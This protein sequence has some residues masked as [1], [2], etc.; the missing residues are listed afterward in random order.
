MKRVLAP[1][2][3]S[4]TPCFSWVIRQDRLPQPFQRLVKLGKPLKRLG[5]FCISATPSSSR[6]L[7]KSWLGGHAFSGRIRAGNRELL[8]LLP[9]PPTGVGGIPSRLVTCDK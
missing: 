5:R 4:L 9:L 6:G 7:M 8:V 1:Q 2:P 3:F